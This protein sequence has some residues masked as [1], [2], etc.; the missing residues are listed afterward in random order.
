MTIPWG[1]VLCNRRAAPPRRHPL[2]LLRHSARAGAALAFLN[3][4]GPAREMV[5]RGPPPEEAG[6]GAAPGV[7]L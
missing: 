6:A 4:A 7:L 3:E 2:A 5:A 1:Q